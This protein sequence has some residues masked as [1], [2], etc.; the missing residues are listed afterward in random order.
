MAATLPKDSLNAIKG[1]TPR[2][3]VEDIRKAKEDATK[4]GAGKRLISPEERRALELKLHRLLVW[5][6]VLT[7]FEFEMGKKKLPLHDIVWDLLAKDCLTEEEKDWVRKLISKLSAHEKED[8]EILHFKDLTHEEAKDIFEEA[9]GLMRAI[10]SLKTLVG[11]K[12]ACGI[13]QR[14]NK[15][16]VE[17]A[18]YW[19]NFLKQIT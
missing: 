16:R 13:H 4:P 19:L 5:V 9:S 3:V 12:D 7:P 8:E 17:E 14:V 6:G 18:Q 10:L 2:G 15:R 11:Q 1:T